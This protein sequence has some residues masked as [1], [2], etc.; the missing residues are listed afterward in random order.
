VFLASRWTDDPSARARAL[1]SYLAR[2]PPSPYRE[3]AIVERGHA[4]ADAGDLA[5]ARG[6]VAE[7]ERAPVPSVVR[8]SL[9]RLAARLR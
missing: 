8:P 7:I 2:R 1:A 4:L 6:A 9:A 5:G 3:Q